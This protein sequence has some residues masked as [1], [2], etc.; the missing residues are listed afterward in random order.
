MSELSVSRNIHTIS[1]LVVNK[2]G[3]L[4][5]IALAFARRGYNIDSLVVSPTVNPRFSR[6]T[7]TAQGNPQ[8]LEQIIKV[9]NKIIDVIHASEH[10]DRDAVHSELALFK[11]KN[12]STNKAIISR[13]IKRFKAWILDETA[14]ALIIEQV[15]TTDQLDELE[16]LLKKYTIFEMVR[17]GKVVMVKGHQET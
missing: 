13:L 3:V 11:V 8:T 7:I 16:A 17:T 2:P 4:V 1:L 6:M 9:S 10:T 15:G 12:S 14:D 5:R